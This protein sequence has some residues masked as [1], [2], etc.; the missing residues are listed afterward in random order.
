MPDTTEL[1]LQ[2]LNAALEYTR[3]ND[4]GVPASDVVETA[5]TFLTFLKSAPSAH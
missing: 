4:S 2:A 3:H 5:D 1:R